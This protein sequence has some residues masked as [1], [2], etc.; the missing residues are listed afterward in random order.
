MSHGRPQI[1]ALI[2]ASR[3]LRVI[4]SREALNLTG[5]NLT[6]CAAE[7]LAGCEVVEIEGLRGFG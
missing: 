6:R 4:L 1:A 7:A 5:V 2:V 3:A